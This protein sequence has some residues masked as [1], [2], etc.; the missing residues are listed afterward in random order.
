MRKAKS[1]LDA[2]RILAE[3]YRDIATKL[4][5]DAIEWHRELGRQAYSDL[6]DDLLTGSTKTKQLR[7]EGHPF[8]KSAFRAGK[9]SKKK[10]VSRPQLPINEQTGRLRRGLFLQE[11]LLIGMQSI[12]IGSAAPYAKFILDPRGTKKMIGRGVMTGHL[13]GMTTPGEIERRW[14]S[15]KKIFNDRFR[16]GIRQ[17]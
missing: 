7:K 14:R 11:T 1:R 16:R 8:A 5:D 4:P 2:Y 15:R 6:K 9:N 10:R 13:F 17:Q 3:R 12:S